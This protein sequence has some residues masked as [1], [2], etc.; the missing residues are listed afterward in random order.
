MAKSRRR[1]SRRSSSGS[2][3]LPMLLVLGGAGV[4]IYAFTQ[5]KKKTPLLV[6]GGTY[7]PP[8]TNNLVNSFVNTIRN[9]FG[10]S[11]SPSTTGLTGTSPWYD[12]ESAMG[13]YP[14]SQ[15]PQLWS[16]DPVTQQPQFRGAYDIDIALA[17]A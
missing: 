10:E 2:N 6:A 9:L 4:A 11:G 5:S 12:L 14:M 16:Y 15:Y 13:K 8:T 17:T 7:T 3:T 1:Y